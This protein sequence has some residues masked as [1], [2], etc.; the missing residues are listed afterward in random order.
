MTTPT[1]DDITCISCGLAPDTDLVQLM[2]GRCFVEGSCGDSMTKYDGACYSKCQTAGEYHN[3]IKCIADCQEKMKL[4]LPDDFRVCLKCHDRC[5]TC[6][7]SSVTTSTDTA[8]A[9]TEY[10]T[11][12]IA[13]FTDINGECLNDIKYVSPKTAYREKSKVLLLEF[14]HTKLV[15]DPTIDNKDICKKC[16]EEYATDGDTKKNSL[17]L[18][19]GTCAVNEFRKKVY[20]KVNEYLIPEGTTGNEKLKFVFKQGCFKLDGTDVY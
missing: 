10:C 16:F 7:N 12:C 11:Q 8:K 14:D 20:L 9:Q 4:D 13:G 17:I 15:I 3:G 5:T 19:N 1:A 18:Q 2:E 6:G